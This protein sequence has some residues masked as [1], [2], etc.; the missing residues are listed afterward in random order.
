MRD[1]LYREFWLPRRVGARDTHERGL[2]RRQEP[3]ARRARQCP[4]WRAGSDLPSLRLSSMKLKCSIESFIIALEH[5]HF[6][7]RRRADAA[8]I[9]PPAAFPLGRA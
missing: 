3:G 1:K 2:S 7:S 4:V 6:I 5:L 8:R 9:R